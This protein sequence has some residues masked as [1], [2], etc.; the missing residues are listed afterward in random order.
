MHALHSEREVR[1]T[2]LICSYFNDGLHGHFPLV[3]AGT[4]TAAPYTASKFAVR[5]LTHCDALE[6]G[7]HAITV[8][9]YAPGVID[10]PLSE[11]RMLNALVHF[12]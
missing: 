6:Y 1:V 10:T 12:E 5:G 8:N 4:A 2:I 9:T 3:N 7:K 11:S